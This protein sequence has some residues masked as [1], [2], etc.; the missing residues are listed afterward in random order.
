MPKEIS[1][2][3]A[4]SS[5]N[6]NI[7][8]VGI[9]WRHFGDI[10][11]ILRGIVDYL[12]KNGSSIV[13]VELT[14]F[15]AEQIDRRIAL[16]WETAS[17]NNSFMFEVEKSELNSCDNAKFHKIAES[18]ACGK[19]TKPVFYGPVWDGETDY[20]KTYSYRLKI[21]DAD[22]KYEFS[23]IVSVT[24]DD[25]TGFALGDIL[26]NP[27][28]NVCSFGFTIE[29]DTYV[30]ISVF[31]LSGKKVMSIAGETLPAGSYTRNIDISNLEQGTYSIVM[32][33]GGKSIMKQLKVVK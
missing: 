27:A 6:K 30:E 11:T 21:F 16:T 3:S 23:N 9:D 1:A 7:I 22:G 14:S 10:E 17:E 25:L 20:G 33:S 12:D 19:S 4:T 26:P 24:I 18:K 13:P 8:Y 31:G 32:A 2:G 15:S 29:T 28:A 5:I